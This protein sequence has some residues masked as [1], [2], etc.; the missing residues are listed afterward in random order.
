MVGNY[1]ILHELLADGPDVF[2]ERRAEHHHLLA[3][4]RVAVDFL[5]IS[6]HV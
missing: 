6:A 1:Y 4:R 3:V 5:H 2:A